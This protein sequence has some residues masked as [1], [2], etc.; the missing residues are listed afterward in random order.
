MTPLQQGRGV[1]PDQ[2]LQGFGH[3]GGE[4]R[5]VLRKSVRLTGIEAAEVEEF[6]RRSVYGPAIRGVGELTLR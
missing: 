5:V 1:T 4:A 3:V 2:L 6:E